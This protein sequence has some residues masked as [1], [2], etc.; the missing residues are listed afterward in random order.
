MKPRGFIPVLRGN[1]VVGGKNGAAAL[2]GVARTTLL[3][4]M[5]RLGIES[6]SDEVRAHSRREAFASVA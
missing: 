6:A 2:L 5:R 3:S 1:G 4:K